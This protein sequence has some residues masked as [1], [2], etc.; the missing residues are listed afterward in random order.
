VLRRAVAPAA[1]GPAGV[2]N[3]MYVGGMGCTLSAYILYRLSFCGR[4]VTGHRCGGCGDSHAHAECLLVL[5]LYRR[6]GLTI[7]IMA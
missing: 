5:S 7:Y 6:R 2:G 4:H 3:Y 1:R